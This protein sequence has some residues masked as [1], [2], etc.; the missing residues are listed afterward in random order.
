MNQSKLSLQ[1]CPR[2]KTHKDLAKVKKY[3]FKYGSPIKF[4]GLQLLLETKKN[5]E[6]KYVDFH[7]LDL[8]KKKEASI[9]GST[10]LLSLTTQ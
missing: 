8:G 6:E 1:F 10:F 4:P 2:K 9:Q 7:V 5:K 3:A